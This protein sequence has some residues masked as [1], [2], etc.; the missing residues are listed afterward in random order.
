MN[1]WSKPIDLGNFSLANYGW[2][3]YELFTLLFAES[4][5]LNLSMLLVESMILIEYF[6]SR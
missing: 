2:S 5:T 4:Y 3:Y 1:M 6:L